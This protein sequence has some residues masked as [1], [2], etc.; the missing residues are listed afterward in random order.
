MMGFSKAPQ[1]DIALL[2]EGTY[3]FV[4]GG[5]A[6][7]VDQIIRAFPQYRF[8]L[9][10][11][12]SHPAH[13]RQM[14]YSLPDHVVHLETHYVH[15]PQRVP[16]PRA[17]LGDPPTFGKVA[18]LHRWFV[19]PQECPQGPGSLGELAFR[20][21]AGG[22]LNQEQFL[23]SQEA[24]RL[25][26][27]LYR[28]RCT[29][30]SFVD[31][32]WTVRALHQALWVLARAAE[33]PFPVRAYHS[34]STGYAGFLATLLHYRT[35]RPLILTEHG[36]YTK[37]RKID[38]AQSSWIRDSRSLFARNPEEA[39][40]LRQLWTRFFE[41]LGRMCY[42]A[43][44]PIIALFEASRQRQIRDGAEA[45]R[46]RIIPNGVAVTQL[47]PLRERR[48]DPPPPVLCLIGRVVPIKDVKTFLRAMRTVVHYLPQ[49][50]GWIVGPEDEDPE[51]ARECRYLAAT[52]GLGSRIKFLGFQKI[53]DLLPRVGLLVL[54]SISEALPLVLL[55]GFAAGVPAV[56]TDVGACREVICGR[57]EEDQ[58]L[59]AAG[60][61]VSIADPQALAEAALELLRDP[62][63]WACAQRAA[64][65]RVEAYYCQDQVWEAYRKIYEEALAPWPAS[66]LSCAKS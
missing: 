14:A 61:V 57:G 12:G 13:Y 56:A 38:L 53:S 3:P 41:T 5:V 43:A 39:A 55:E 4:R 62:Q 65:R 8:A 9:I 34:I 40:Y 25:I 18:E 52:L 31:Y 21:L 24:W 6:N 48:S 35:G 11:V 26:T 17:L 59:G 20:L 60:R 42:G 63:K 16:P 58:A 46:T 22:K 29:D 36:I 44:N 37:E 32:F 64:I 1:A 10:F 2:L 23:Y 51:Y 66:A 45:S 49:A 54:S 27:S 7:W 28:Q 19:A 50:E 33:N 30:P 47:A 15:A